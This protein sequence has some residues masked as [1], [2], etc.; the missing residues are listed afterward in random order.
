MQHEVLRRIGEA[1]D[2]FLDVLLSAAAPMV[3]D[4]KNNPLRIQGRVDDRLGRWQHILHQTPAQNI[5]SD[6]KR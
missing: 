1:T 5:R 2:Q 3:G 4:V 6:G